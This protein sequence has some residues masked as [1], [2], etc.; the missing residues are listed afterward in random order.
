M[1]DVSARPIRVL[2]DVRTL[3]RAWASS[4][5]A[6]N[7]LIISSACSSLCLICRRL[8]RPKPHPP[9]DPLSSHHPSSSTPIN[10]YKYLSPPTLPPRRGPSPTSTVS[11]SAQLLHISSLIAY[12]SI[13]LINISQCLPRSLP[14]LPLP[15]RLPLLLLTAHTRV[16]R[17]RCSQTVWI[18][19]GSGRRRVLISC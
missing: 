11:C 18:C 1:L 15:R 4:T 19:F 16:C 12:P 13:P 9:H 5:R 14:A 2:P 6:G 3:I 10:A 8:P 17:C 7:S